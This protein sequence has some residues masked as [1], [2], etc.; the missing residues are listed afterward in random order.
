M[1]QLIFLAAGMFVIG[2]DNYVMA[3]LLPGIGASLG[4]S[5]A[6]AGQGITAF[7]LAYV[8]SAP[9]F[10]V[11][12]AKKQARVMLVTGLT[13][14]VL[15]NLLTLLSGSLVIYLASRA[16]VGIGAGLFTPVAAAAAAK[17]A[18][19]DR[20]G[21]ALSL[22]WGC[23]SAGAVIGVPVGLWLAG[24][25]GW[26]ATLLVISG[27]GAITLGMTTWQSAVCVVTQPK[28]WER[29]CFLANRR[30]LAVAG[31][32]L[33][34]A[35][36]SLGLYSY[37]G[38]LQAGAAH[39]V[40]AALSVWNIGG[41]IGSTVIGYVVD[42]TEQPKSVMVVILVALIAAISLLP[43]SHS[44]SM[45]NL[46]PY[47]LWGAM[48]WATVTPQQYTL[49]GIHPEQSTSLVAL[50][51]S[52]IGLGSALGTALGGLAIANGFG[53]HHLVYAVTALLGC[54][55]VLQLSLIKQ[56]PQEIVSACPTR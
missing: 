16:I 3:G 7:D 19:P 49:I 42:R 27:L 18:G 55:L 43:V 14:L 32:T 51:S 46:C 12:L 31:V 38:L 5:I 29:I 44:I 2:C 52:A 20:K 41:L 9:L 1:R 25:T 50:N 53:A 8:V 24:M 11:L 21:R 4:V 34:T 39:S 10:A 15:G 6:A 48:G 30:V 33:L 26:Q 28:L 54:A 56:S 35:T 13:L 22:I 40:A 36:G 23:N 45:L 37:V 47:L 17:L